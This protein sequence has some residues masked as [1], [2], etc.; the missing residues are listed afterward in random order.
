MLVVDFACVCQT[1]L[2]GVNHAVSVRLYHRYPCIVCNA[3]DVKI[4]GERCGT[5]ALLIDVSS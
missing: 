4:M 1:A 5:E 2:T 3:T